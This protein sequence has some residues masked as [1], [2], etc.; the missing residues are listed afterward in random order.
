MS[1]IDKLCNKN[2]RTNNGETAMMTMIMIMVMS[3][4]MM[5]NIIMRMMMMKVYGRSV[6]LDPKG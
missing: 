5:M 3:T 4:M 2:N 6:F 1:H